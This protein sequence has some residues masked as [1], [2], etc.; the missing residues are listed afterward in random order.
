[1]AVVL[2]LVLVILGCGCLYLASPHQK[3]LA[4]A[5][6]RRPAVLAGSVLLMAGLAAWIVALRPLAGFFVAL[7]VAMVCLFVF[8]YAAALRSFGR[9][10]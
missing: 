4:H 8:P 9:R 5:L 1:M 10:H 3:W 7:H 6:P 2:A